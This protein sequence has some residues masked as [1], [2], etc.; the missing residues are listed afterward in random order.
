MELERSQLLAEIAAQRASKPPPA[1]DTA[2]TALL[3]AAADLLSAERARVTQVLA[4]GPLDPLL[5]PI[6]IGLLEHAALI[7]PVSDALGAIVDRIVGQL[8]DALHDPALPAAVRRRIPRI[9]RSAGHARAAEGLLDAMRSPERVL[10]FRAASALSVLT[11]EHAELAPRPDVVFELVRSELRGSGPEAV[12]LQH[13]LTI[14]SL[15]LDRDALRL[16][17]EALSSGDA[18]QRGTALEYLHS[19]LPEPLRGEMVAWLET[20]DASVDR[21]TAKST[22]S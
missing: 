22:A 13:V 3:M 4:R 6:A 9:L 7:G 12:S 17:R 19:T 11:A 8:V 2:H 1:P 5:V 16:S 20:R 15:V 14:L 21:A 10:R 18:R